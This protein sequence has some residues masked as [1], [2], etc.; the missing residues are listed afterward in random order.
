MKK[1]DWYPGRNEEQKNCIKA[2]MRHIKVTLM[3]LLGKM[4]SFKTL[5]SDCSSLKENHGNILQQRKYLNA[6]L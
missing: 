3:T 4:Y 5:N 2:D 1:N 6:I